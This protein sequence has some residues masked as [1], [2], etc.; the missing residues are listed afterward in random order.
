[1]KAAGMMADVFRGT[2]MKL[3]NDILG[4]PKKILHGTHHRPTWSRVRISCQAY[5][6]M[7]PPHTIGGH[8]SDMMMTKHELEQ[9]VESK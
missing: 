6:D 4:L 9:S 3:N 8:H 5:A 7:L 1:M 2:R